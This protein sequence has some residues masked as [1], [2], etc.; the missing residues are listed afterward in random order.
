MIINVFTIIAVQNNYS[1]TVISSNAFLLF[2]CMGQAW[3]LDCD[4]Q[5]FIIILLIIYPMWKWSRSPPYAGIIEA[6]NF[7]TTAIPYLIFITEGFLF[8]ILY[9][10][11]VNPDIP[12]YTFL[13]RTLC[14]SIC[15][16]SICP[17]HLLQM[18]CI[19]GVTNPTRR[20][21]KIHGEKLLCSLVQIFP[22]H[23]GCPHGIHSPQNKRQRH[24]NT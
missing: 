4:M 7:A 22:L 17:S 20:R 23:L 18:A 15:S 9:N 5:M 8:H 16:S 6:G 2:Q 21:Y 10:T 14:P 11:Q 13:F 19:D 12:N 24:Q 3:Y 1:N